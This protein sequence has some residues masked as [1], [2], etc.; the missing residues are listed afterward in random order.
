MKKNYC[1]L[2]IFLL[3][4]SNSFSQSGNGHTQG[5]TL[6]YTPSTPS[7][8]SA[9]TKMLQDVGSAALAKSTINND[10]AA[11][12]FVNYT[13]DTG[14]DSVYL[15]YTTNGDAPNKTTG[16]TVN[17]A[18]SNYSDPNRTWYATIPV[19]SA[20]TTVKY[21]F[22]ISNNTL[23]NGYGVVDTNGYAAS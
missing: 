7:G 5:T 8:Y 21:V 3:I 1:L 23:A 20:G 12:A 9:A 14:S 4:F 16:T 10:A 15:R 18:F 2:A 11:H 6:S 13:W 22:Y 17:G 19:Q